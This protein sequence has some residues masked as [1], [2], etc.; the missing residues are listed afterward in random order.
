MEGR[1][2]KEREEVDGDRHRGSVVGARRGKDE[3]WAVCIP[4]PDEM[5]RCCGLMRHLLDTVQMQV[6]KREEERAFEGVRIDMIDPD[7]RCTFH[8]V[9]RAQTDAPLGTH[10]R[11]VVGVKPLAQLL[12]TMHLT[13]ECVLH[14][15]RAVGDEA[16]ITL[17]KIDDADLVAYTLPTLEKEADSVEL[18]DFEM[19]IACEVDIERV[20][21]VVK[22]AV[23]MHAGDVVVAVE[24][25]KDGNARFLRLSF[26]GD[27]VTR[28]DVLQS[29]VR[30]DDKGSALVAGEAVDD[31]RALRDAGNI[32]TLFEAPFPSSYLHSMTKGIEKTYVTL[33]MGEGLPLMLQYTIGTVESEIRMVLAPSEGE[34]G[35]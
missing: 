16:P 5:A 6:I 10:D 23:E 2:R 32:E 13:T 30:P 15:S 25:Q 22:A 12:Q 11:F 26:A 24:R 35:E 8:M 3:Q 14:L 31:W 28:D 29:N 19:P 34:E 17:T 33:G 18:R 1:K 4:F 21:R 9:L 27:E 7:E 20:K